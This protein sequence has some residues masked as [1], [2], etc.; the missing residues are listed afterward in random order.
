MPHNHND[1]SRQATRHRRR[2]RPTL[3]SLEERLTPSA[4]TTVTESAANA[5]QLQ[6]DLNNA[7]AA[8][9]QYI[10]NLTGVSADYNLTAGQEL[11]SAAA[12]GSSVTIAGTGQS[13]T[14]NGNRVFLVNIGAQ[15]H[16]PGYDDHGRL[17]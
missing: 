16:L 5:A 8:N 15:R 9:T 3:E 12:S 7:T 1:R 17:G 14:G 11:T 10:I 2:V 4:P 6:T 13:I